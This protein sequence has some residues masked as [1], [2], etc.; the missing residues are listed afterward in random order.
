MVMDSERLEKVYS[1]YSG[2]YDI[3]FGRFFHQSRA[4]AIRLLDIQKG[5]HVL[6]VGVGTGLSLPYYPR[7]CQVT[8]I[9]FCDPML[10]KGRQ[11][12]ARQG[13]GDHIELRQMDAMRMSFGDNSFDS[14]FA[15]YVITAVPDPRQVLAEMI[16]VCRPNGKI[17]LL[18]H[19][20]N[21]NRLISTCER[22]ASPICRRLGFQPD[23]SLA[24]L[25]EG[26]PLSVEKTGPVKPLNYWKVV[27]CTNRKSTQWRGFNGA[28]LHSLRGA[29]RS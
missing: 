26:A 1:V 9:D 13:L 8:G 18:N 20:Q 3:V 10:D 19:F 6:E 11:R 5:D 4:Q 27:Q 7:H 29:V 22:V 25:L 15:A 23:L 12:V 2:F 14:V 16:R 21:G 24:S 17:V 28:L